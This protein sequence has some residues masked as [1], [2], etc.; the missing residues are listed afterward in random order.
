MLNQFPLVKARI[1]HVS[2][3]V[4]LGIHAESEV[5]MAISPQTPFFLMENEQDQGAW[6]LFFHASFFLSIL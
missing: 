2:L 4:L 5:M 6:T 3:G 1:F